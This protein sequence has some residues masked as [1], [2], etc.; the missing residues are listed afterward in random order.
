MHE[1]KRLTPVQWKRKGIYQIS[2]TFL[3]LKLAPTDFMF[4]L[5]KQHE[6]GHRAKTIGAS[7]WRMRIITDQQAADKCKGVFAAGDI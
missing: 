4:S 1:G 5:N 7:S 3:P 2:N 6:F